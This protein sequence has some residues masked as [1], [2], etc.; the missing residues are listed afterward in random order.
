MTNHLAA[1]TLDEIT[2]LKLSADSGQRSPEV[3]DAEV[4]RLED[5][6]G[7]DALGIYLRE[8]GRF[9]R[10]TWSEELR[11]AERIERSRRRAL[12]L[13]GKSPVALAEAISLGDRIAMRRLDGEGPDGRGL[14]ARERTLLRGLS[15]IERVKLEQ[16]K[17]QLRMGGQEPARRTG[18]R[19]C[20]GRSSKLGG[21]IRAILAG[22]P[23]TAAMRRRMREALRRSIEE[24]PAGSRKAA[25]ALYRAVL[26]AEKQA[27]AASHRLVECNLRLVVSIAKRY[28]NRGLDFPDLIEE[29]NIGLVK[30]AE[31]FDRR[32]GLRFAPIAGFKIRAS[33]GLALHKR[34]RAVR[35]PSQLLLV[36]AEVSRA[37]RH[38]SQELERSPSP[39][40]LA[41]RTKLPMSEVVEAL[42]AMQPLRF[43]DELFGEDGDL[44]PRDAGLS[45]PAD[46]VTQE[47]F[48]GEVREVVAS[49]LCALSPRQGRV[50]AERFGLGGRE[51]RTLEEI[52]QDLSLT[53]ERVRQIEARA[54]TR[55]RRSQVAR[56]LSLGCTVS[57]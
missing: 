29:G 52:G 25:E 10:L 35:I 20:H 15:E 19:T 16:V 12:R 50:I 17:L 41:E 32:R 31:E 7:K 26:E 24:A 14:S 4:E 36:M 49:A 21:K 53:R 22:L 43:L 28:R 30:A 56:G 9:P 27:E 48:E 47:I 57:V 46:S 1:E 18:R 54:L 38:L 33:I 11:I 3:E 55:L 45:V 44:S 39:K 13:L 37:G 40:E 51:A 5:G 2:A 23:F 8:V 42:K 34:P 6:A